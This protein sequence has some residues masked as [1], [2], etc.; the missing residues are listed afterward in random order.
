MRTGASESYACLSHFPEIFNDVIDH[1]LHARTMQRRDVLLTSAEH[2]QK[3]ISD[4]QHWHPSACVFP[5]IVWCPTPDTAVDEPHI[6]SFEGFA[7]HER[8]TRFLSSPLRK[9]HYDFQNRARP[10]PIPTPRHVNDQVDRYCSCTG[11]DFIGRRF[12]A[13]NTP[14]SGSS[15]RQSPRSMRRRHAPRERCLRENACPSCCRQM[16]PRNDLLI[17]PCP[18]ATAWHSF[19]AAVG[20]RR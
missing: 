18:T 20:A 9:Q 13:G 16:R 19:F 15:D 17:L 7:R 1:E 5:P 12:T 8:S 11:P 2:A 4:Y 6:R 14:P 10:Y 3:A